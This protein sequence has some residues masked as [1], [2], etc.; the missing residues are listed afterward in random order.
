M[1]FLG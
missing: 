1:E